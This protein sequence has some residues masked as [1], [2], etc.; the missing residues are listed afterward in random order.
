MLK[1]TI[2]CIQ[3]HTLALYSVKAG[4]LSHGF[5][6]F[7][8]G[9]HDIH[10]FNRKAHLAPFLPSHPVV[11]MQSVNASSSLGTVSAAPWGSSAI[12]PIS[13]AYIKVSTAHH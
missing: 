2:E 3:T 4:E 9:Y 13:W 12:L 7:Q 5:I 11:P 8:F 6:V 1:L 10:L